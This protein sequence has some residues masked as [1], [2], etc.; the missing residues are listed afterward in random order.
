MLFSLPPQPMGWAGAIEFSSDLF[1]FFVPSIYNHYYGA[2]VIKITNQIDFAK[3]IFENF[4]YPG[5]TIILTLGYIAVALSRKKL[6]QVK[7]KLGPFLITSLFFAILTMGP[8]LH[9]LGIWTLDLDQGIK[10]VIPLPFA[11]L[12]YLPFLSNVRVPGRFAVGLIFFGY[13]VVA[14]LINE[15]LKNKSRK[16]IIAS[17]LLLLGVFIIDHRYQDHD[18]AA[19]RDVPNKIYQTIAEDKD[20]QS[21][22]MRVPFGVRDGLMYFGSVNHI[23]NNEGQEI[24]RKPVIGGYAGRLPTH[25]FTYYLNNPLLGYLGF[26]FDPNYETNGFLIMSGATQPKTFDLQSSQKAADFLNIKYVILEKPAPNTCTELY[27]SMEK[28]EL[29]GFSQKM[30]DADYLLFSRELGGEELLEVNLGELGDELMLSLGWLDR[31]DGFRWSNKNS[32]VMFNIK[33]EREIILEFEAASFYQDQ[34]V[35]IYLN[36]ELAG[37]LSVSTD[38]NVYNLKLPQ[39]RRGLNTIHFIFEQSFR[40]KDILVGNEDERELSAKFYRVTLREENDN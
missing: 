38:K 29:L 20:D 7:N 17:F 12:H 14:I 4:S 13:I 22:V 8:F 16:V 10:L 33:Q 23:L 40:P 35:N 30:E 27:H 1:G 28:I 31:E 2:A 9:V 18:F 21:V 26:I 25:A 6:G 36:K 15:L 24:H 39:L 11:V 34:K 5:I 37:E 19:P 3:G 32:S